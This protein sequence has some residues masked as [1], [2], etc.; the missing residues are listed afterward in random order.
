[1]SEGYGR[2]ASEVKLEGYTKTHSKQ[3]ATLHGE[4]KMLTWYLVDE[5]PNRCHA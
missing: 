3:V 2:Y 4:N 1:M 5:I